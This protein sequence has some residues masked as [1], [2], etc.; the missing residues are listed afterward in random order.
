[1]FIHLI[2]FSYMN[3]YDL[4]NTSREFILNSN[5]NYLNTVY[6]NC[7]ERKTAY[8]NFWPVY[9]DNDGLLGNKKEERVKAGICSST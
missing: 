8:T 4:Q 2:M 5:S 1:M 6:D 3:S 7:A 9:W